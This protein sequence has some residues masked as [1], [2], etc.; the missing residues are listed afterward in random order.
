MDYVKG[1]QLPGV[2]TRCHQLYGRPAQDYL[3]SRA[4]SDINERPC[5][6]S[7]H[8]LCGKRSAKPANQLN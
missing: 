3:K 8:P 5:M 1:L 2:R 4:G 6:C 7:I